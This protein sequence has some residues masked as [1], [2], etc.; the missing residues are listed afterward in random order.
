MINGPL[1]GQCDAIW[2]GCCVLAVASALDRRT[3][4]MSA[5]AGLG[6]A[7][8]AQA[9]FLAPFC[10]VVVMRERKWAALAIPPVIYL[11]AV[12]P[13]WLAGWPIDNLLTIYARQYELLPWLTTGPNLWAPA[14]ALHVTPELFFTAGYVLTAGA[15]VLYVAKVH[16]SLLAAL[17]S[18][19]LLPFLLPKMHERYFLLADVLAY[20]LA[21]TDPRM[22][23]VFVLVQVGSLLSLVAYGTSLPWFNVTGAAAM[24]AALVLT[25][26][27]LRRAAPEVTDPRGDDHAHA[28]PALEGDLAAELRS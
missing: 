2:V 22:K 15:V 21:W 17:L 28:E 3:Y 1:L 14:V 11:A 10:L 20:C 27:E 6:F 19:I 13:A 12:L 18:A 23:L 24:T 5:W 4:A 26:R 9:L 16:P 7:F 8:K 25:I